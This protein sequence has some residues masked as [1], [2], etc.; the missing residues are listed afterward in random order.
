MEKH[1]LPHLERRLF[2]LKDIFTKMSDNSD[3]DELLKIIHRP[4]WTTPAEFALVISAVESLNAQARNV[5]SLR[6][7]LVSSSRQ[8][9]TQKATAA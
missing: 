2:E 6:T 3:L 5:A 7:A 9:G 8:V 4:G 1:D